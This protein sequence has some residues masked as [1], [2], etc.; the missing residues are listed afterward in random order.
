M[1]GW[2][3]LRIKDLGRVVTGK[4]PPTEAKEFFDG[5]ELFVSPK[6]LSWDQYFV[7]ETETQVTEKAFA[8]FK[9]QVLPTNTVMFTS[10]S[11]AFGKMGLTSRPSL[12]NQQINSVIVNSDHDFR[13]V[14]YLL[15]TYKEIIFSYNS[16]IDTPIVPK[17]VFEGIE[18][19]C[20]PKAIQQKIAAILSAY[21]DLIANNQ[22]RITLLER[23]AEDIYREWFVR[24]RFPGHENA[25]IEKGVPQG[26]KFVELSALANINAASLKKGSDTDWIQYIDI[27]A[28][29]TNHIDDV[30]EIRLA[31]A[32]GRARR[33]VKHGDVIWSSVRPANRAYCLIYEPTNNLVASTGF[34]VI[35]PKLGIPFT[36]I[37]FAVTSDSFV[38]QMAMVAKG[39]A[40]PATSFDDFGKAKVLRPS[41]ELLERFHSQSESMFKRRQQ[42]RKTNAALAQQRDALLPRLISG[43]LSVDALDIRFPPGMQKQDM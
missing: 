28:V 3:K 36:F 4:T 42:L 31:D 25:K 8:K 18:V 29:S 27:S 6:D 30:P 34:A 26:W 2:S 9:N 40:Y 33:L 5:D 24:L 14:F 7:A 21:D 41:T 16:G 37:N 43:K 17:S 19:F 23:M 13:F 35:S 22:R 10:L 11:F 38:E 20:P 39:A 32:P 15:K 12:T 1:S